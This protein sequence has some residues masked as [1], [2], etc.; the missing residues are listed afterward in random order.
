MRFFRQTLLS[1]CLI[2]SCA[3]A[4][5][6]PIA[7]DD[8]ALTHE[9]TAVSFSVTVND[10]DPSAA[11]IDPAT[12]DLDPL[13][14]GLDQGPI[15]TSEG[16]FS[17]DLLGYVTFTPVADYFG[18][19]TLQYTVQ[20]NDASPLTSP[21]GNIT[22]VV[23]DTPVA[24]DDNTT[25]FE[26]TPVT[27]DVTT[28]DTDD[29][30]IDNTTVDLNTVTLGRQT[31]FT[32]ASGLWEVT[33]SGEVTYT[34]AL[35]F[36]GSASVT[37]KVSDNAGLVSDNEATLTV[38]VTASNDAPVAVNDNTGTAEDT[39]VTINVTTNDTDVDGNSSIDAGSVDLD[40]GTAAQQTSLTNASGLWEVSA[41]GVV[42][43][44]PALN[45][46][47]SAS[48]T[49]TV[50]DNSGAT[51]NSA[52]LSVTVTA[53]NDA[54]TITTIL[55]QSIAEDVVGGTGALSFTVGD[56]DTPVA[57][58]TLTG[59]SDN[60]ALVP[61][62]NIVFGGSSAA[63]NVT[64]TPVA[65]Q[66]GIANITITV[67]DGNGGSTPTTFELTVTAVNDPPAAVNDNTTTTEDTP[68][69]IIVT[70]N[71][72]DVDGTVDVATVDLN[73][74]TP[75]IN[76]TFS[77]AAGSWNVNT[78]TGQVTYTPTLNFSGTAAVTY[79]VNDNTGGTS[80]TA[81]LSVTVTVSETLKVPRFGFWTVGTS[82]TVIF[83]IAKTPRILR[84]LTNS[85]NDWISVVLINR[86]GIKRVTDSTTVID[87]ETVRLISE[88]TAVDSATVMLSTM[89]ISKAKLAVTVS[90]TITLSKIETRAMIT[91][92]TDSVRPIDSLTARS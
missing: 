68:V 52:T 69:S 58:L 55:P 73:P 66:S 67:S 7:V 64:V 86:S 36:N 42:T 39:P 23:N 17:V 37:Y 28:N 24:V 61:D 31:S 6:Q 88:K 60:N 12:V 38:T 35:N 91:K 82:V 18:S 81:T 30:D 45:F 19:V 13:T 50:N 48:V 90:L 54:P 26:D 78:T 59:A 49:Y 53:S 9:N 47:G 46:N 83:S 72:S 25:G 34:P 77:N 89:L 32:N 2:L 87:S 62:A 20:N 70:T 41:T 75:V 74:A 63:R 15:I 33:T 10:D 76:S 1:V 57:S 21:P 43:Y 27:F 51:S 16:T 71:D 4:F 14:P 22:V 8:N 29:G 3:F 79:R 44:T 56:V 80:N 65:N 40:P 85:T 92:L 11:D 5:G 84:R